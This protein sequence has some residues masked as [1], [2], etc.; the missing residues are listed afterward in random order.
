MQSRKRIAV[1]Q[2]MVGRSSGQPAEIA[3]RPWTDGG[4]GRGT[5]RCLL[6]CRTL[7]AMR[8]S[9]ASCSAAL[10]GI[11]RLACHGSLN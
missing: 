1:M 10:A 11:G 4:F 5:M 2:E 7:A 8:S 9:R 6:S 3:R